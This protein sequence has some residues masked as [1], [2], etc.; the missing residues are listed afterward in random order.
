MLSSGK[1]DKETTNPTLDINK[2]ARAPFSQKMAFTIIKD[3]CQ[4]LRRSSGES[5][6]VKL[7]GGR[8]D[9]GLRQI[10]HPEVKGNLPPWHKREEDR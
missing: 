8:Q 6:V 1:A 10:S 9:A 5:V 4:V 2:A 7:V 3:T